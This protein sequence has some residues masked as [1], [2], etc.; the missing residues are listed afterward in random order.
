MAEHSAPVVAWYAHHQGAGHVTRAVAV[1]S[2]MTTEVVILSSAVRPSEWPEDHWVQLPDDAD[3]GGTDHT[4]GGVVH[5]APL[6]H[7][8]YRQRMG[9]VADWVLHHRPRLVVSDVSVEVALLARLLGIPVVVTVMAGD[10]ADRPHTAAYDAATAL[11]AAWPPEVGGSV[12]RGWASRWD[13]KTTFVGAFS[14]FDDRRAEPPQGRRQVTVLWGRGDTA[15]D[16]VTIDAAMAATPDWSWTLC[17]GT[18]SADA[19]WEHLQ[20]AD[21]VVLHGG[22]NA[23]AEVAAARRPAIVLPQSRPHDEQ[24]HLARG[25]AHLGLG[26][27][28]ASWPAATAWPD[29]L[30]TASSAD[31]AAWS[32]WSDGGGAARYARRLDALVGSDG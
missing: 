9:L 6:D 30:A 15:S 5:W 28:Q 27:P 32:H 24:L 3:G 12:V 19:V 22:Q 25:L 16:L 18:T 17:D 4:A 21:V 8:G 11:V 31:P 29:L 23:V 2:R 20:S 1:A 7:D 13:E 14:R 10:R 26:H